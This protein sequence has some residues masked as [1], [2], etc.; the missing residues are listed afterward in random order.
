MVNG[1]RVKPYFVIDFGPQ[2]ENLE[3]HSVQNTACPAL[4][5]NSV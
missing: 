3:L 2:D 5:R 1:H 4:E